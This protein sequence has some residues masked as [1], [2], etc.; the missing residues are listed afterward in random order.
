MGRNGE[1]LGQSWRGCPSKFPSQ[2]ASYHQ[3]SFKSVKKEKKC[4]IIPA[5]NLNFLFA[6][7]SF[8]T[9]HKVKSRQKNKKTSAPQTI[10]FQILVTEKFF[11]LGLTIANYYLLIFKHTFLHMY[12]S[13]IMILTGKGVI[14]SSKGCWISKV[15]FDRESYPWQV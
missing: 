6:L 9:Y 1:T 5:L 3:K 13:Y 12:E 11:L 4:C 7:L 8:W 15:C 10:F 14:K 2:P